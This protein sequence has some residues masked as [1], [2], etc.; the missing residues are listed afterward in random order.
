MFDRVIVVDWSGK[1]TRSPVRESRDAV[2]IGVAEAARDWDPK[3][4]RTPE[5]AM[6][7]LHER[8]AEGGRRLVG[9]GRVGGGPCEP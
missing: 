1:A 4:C 6:T 8:L 5:E 3:Y 7:G 9:S 2:W